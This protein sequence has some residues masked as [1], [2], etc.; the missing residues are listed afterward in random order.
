MGRPSKY[1]PEFAQRVAVQPP[2]DHEEKRA[3]AEPAEIF[4]EGWTC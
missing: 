3:F 2:G 1:K 4:A